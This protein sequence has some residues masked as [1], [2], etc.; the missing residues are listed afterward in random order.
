MI[1]IYWS[2]LLY[3]FSVPNS[4]TL[5]SD[6][7][8]WFFKINQRNI[9]R[10]SRE[11]EKWVLSSHFKQRAQTSLSWLDSGFHVRLFSKCCSVMHWHLRD[12]ARLYTMNSSNACLAGNLSNCVI[13]CLG[14]GH[15]GWSAGWETLRLIL[16]SYLPHLSWLIVN[17]KFRGSDHVNSTCLSL[18][19]EVWCTTKGFIF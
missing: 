3:I 12:G 15:Y 11:Q 10:I 4:V 6:I 14:R 19:P 16:M 18:L 2:T 13:G 7:F 1:D 5:E 17:C 9:I 8:Y